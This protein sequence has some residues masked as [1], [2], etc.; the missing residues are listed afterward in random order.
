MRVA[1]HEHEAAPD[2]RDD[3][4]EKQGEL[5][6]LEGGGLDRLIRPHRAER[7]A[8]H[9]GRHGNGRAD[10]EKHTNR[11]EADLAVGRKDPENRLMAMLVCVLGV[12]PGPAGIRMAGKDDG[13][14]VVAVLGYKLAV[15]ILRDLLVEEHIEPGFVKEYA[16]HEPHKTCDPRK[17]HPVP[18]GADGKCEIHKPAQNEPEP[19]GIRNAADGRAR[20]YGKLLFDRFNADLTQLFPHV[21]G[22]FALALGAGK[23]RA[24]L[25][26]RMFDDV[27]RGFGVLSVFFFHGVLPQNGFLK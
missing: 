23:P 16:A 15:C 3:R 4:Q 20:R 1:P 13:V 11:A 10:Q 2:R 19:A 14:V 27:K 25:M 7:S 21:G 18:Q 6:I 5:E 17:R 22:V 24:D 12:P 26:R 9:N 8:G